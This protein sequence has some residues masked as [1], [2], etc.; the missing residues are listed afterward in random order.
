MAGVISEGGWRVCLAS[1][2]S[3]RIMLCQRGAKR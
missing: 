3:L 1:C 2:Q